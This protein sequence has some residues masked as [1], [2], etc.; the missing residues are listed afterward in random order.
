MPNFPRP[1][2]GFPHKSAAWTGAALLSPNFTK[3]NAHFP[4]RLPKPMRHI[5][6]GDGKAV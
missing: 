5:G 6:I 2:V 3:D 4:L 1:R